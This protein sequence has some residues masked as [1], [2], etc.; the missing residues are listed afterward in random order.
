MGKSRASDV[1]KYRW[2]SREFDGSQSIMQRKNELLGIKG[3][4]LGLSTSRVLLES[5]FIP[6]YV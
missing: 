2:L 6:L 3:F 4:F 5:S 1:D